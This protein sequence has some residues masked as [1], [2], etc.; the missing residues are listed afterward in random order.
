MSWN[1]SNIIKSQSNNKLQ[2][3]SHNPLSPY[4]SFDLLLSCRDPQNFPSFNHFQPS[5]QADSSLFPQGSTTTCSL[6]VQLL[7]IILAFL[8]FLIFCY[9][10]PYLTPQILHYKRRPRSFLGIEK[11]FF[12]LLLYLGGNRST[13]MTRSH[14]TFPTSFLLQSTQSPFLHLT[15]KWHSSQ[16]FTIFILFLD[17]SHSL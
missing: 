13:H 1:F 12:I 17:N 15:L 6:I 7:W 4:F 8:A 9:F 3:T 11:R 10:L 14:H 2:T 16:S 5:L